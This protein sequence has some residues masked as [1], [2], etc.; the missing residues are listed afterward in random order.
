MLKNFKCLIIGIIIIMLAPLNY[1]QSAPPFFDFEISNCTHGDYGM[2]CDQFF[3]EWEEEPLDFNINIIVR[4]T[5][6]VS[7][8][9]KL[10][11]YRNRE[12]I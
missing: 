9:Y 6:F 2:I 7:P 3:A 5:H 12:L 10:R 11:I 1:P 8:R 4:P